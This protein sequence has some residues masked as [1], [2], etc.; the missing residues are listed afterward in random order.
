MQVVNSGVDPSWLE[1]KVFVN[2]PTCSCLYFGAK[3][4]QGSLSQSEDH[5]LLLIVASIPWVSNT[6]AFRHHHSQFCVQL[7]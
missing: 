6:R 5:R 4:L 3:L 7:F 1:S 2:C